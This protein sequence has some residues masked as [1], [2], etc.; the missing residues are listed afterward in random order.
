MI[1][2]VYPFIKDSHDTSNICRHLLGE[3][4][5]IGIHSVPAAMVDGWATRFKICPQEAYSLVE[6][7][8]RFRKYFK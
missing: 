5:G 8:P 2:I 6:Y 1:H 3:R 4:R 7:I